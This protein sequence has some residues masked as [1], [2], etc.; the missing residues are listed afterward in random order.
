MTT[1]MHISHA[2]KLVA[3]SANYGP[4]AATLD[5]RRGIEMKPMVP[6]SFGAPITADANGYVASQNLTAL[7]VFSSSVTVAAALAAAALAG[8]A[9]VARNV[10]AAWTGTATMTVTGLDAYGATVVESSG[11][12]TSMTGKKAFKSITNI[13]VSGDVTSLTVGTGDVLG[14]P[15]ALANLEDLLA[16]NVDGS[17]E[18]AAPVVADTTDPATATDG[19]CRGTVD[20]TQAQ[21]GTRRCAVLFKV[22]HSGKVAAF[23]VDQFSG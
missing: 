7:G 22:D 23:G 15:F 21:N 19:D 9:D 18:D 13:E 10:V 11:S 1:H 2:D 6:H 14:L 4:Y 17:V 20:F 12:G 8:V 16:A 5:G 3:G